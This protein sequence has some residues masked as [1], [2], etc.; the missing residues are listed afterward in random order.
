MIISEKEQH[1]VL[2][3]KRL[4]RGAYFEPLALVHSLNIIY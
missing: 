2:L 1:N 3:V 4:V